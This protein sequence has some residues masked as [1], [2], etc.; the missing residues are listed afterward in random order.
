MAFLHPDYQHLY[1]AKGKGGKESAK[2][3][4]GGGGR[5]GNQTDSLAAAGTESEAPTALIGKCEDLVYFWNF[6]H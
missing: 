3:V 4:K 6:L 2:V 5:G 1:A